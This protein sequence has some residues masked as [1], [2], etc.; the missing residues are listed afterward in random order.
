MLSKYSEL[1]LDDLVKKAQIKFDNYL[2]PIQ[3]G[4]QYMKV[5]ELKDLP[6]MLVEIESKIVEDFFIAEA[7]KLS[8][9]VI[10]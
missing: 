4:S 3:L 9:S 2:D 8:K 7:K 10:I 6:H 5:S 1:S